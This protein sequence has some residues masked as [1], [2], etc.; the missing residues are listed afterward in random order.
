MEDKRGADR[1]KKLGKRTVRPKKNEH[2][3]KDFPQGCEKKKKNL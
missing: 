3:F 2:K 1:E